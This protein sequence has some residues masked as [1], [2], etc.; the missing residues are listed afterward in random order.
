MCFFQSRTLQLNLLNLNDLKTKGLKKQ[1]HM[2]AILQQE[3]NCLSEKVYNLKYG[4]HA[5]QNIN[6]CLY[7]KYIFN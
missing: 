1:N 3:Y 2:I 4:P 5:K 6:V 7:K